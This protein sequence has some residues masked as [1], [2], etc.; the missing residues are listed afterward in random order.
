VRVE[1]ADDGNSE[2]NEKKESKERESETVD[3]FMRGIIT[4]L[5]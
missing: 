1:I 5:T 2:E 3:T 4:V